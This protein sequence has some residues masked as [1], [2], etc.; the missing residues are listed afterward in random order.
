MDM[1]ISS[2]CTMRTQSIMMALCLCFTANGLV[3]RKFV[4]LTSK[5]T[6]EHRR[7]SFTLDCP[8]ERQST[9]S[10]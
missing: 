2:C 8:F 6:R 7:R 10:L 4:L 5:W 3:R 1:Q 9:C